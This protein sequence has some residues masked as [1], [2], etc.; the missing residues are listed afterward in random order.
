MIKIF[1]FKNAKKLLNL[2]DFS[3]YDLSQILLDV[4]YIET[5]RMG[6]RCR[7]DIL[8]NNECFNY[9]NYS[10]YGSMNLDNYTRS[11]CIRKNHTTICLYKKKGANNNGR[12]F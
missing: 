2:K 8:D 12:N 7:I 11:I 9:D 10:I 1:H 5:K 6:A 4:Y 3:I